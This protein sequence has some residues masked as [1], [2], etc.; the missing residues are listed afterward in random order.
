MT[1]LSVDAEA[2]WRGVPQVE[3]LVSLL[4]DVAR[5]LDGVA[6][7]AGVPPVLAARVTTTAM[8]G[9]RD[10]RARAR[11]LAGV[12]EDLRRRVAAARLADAPLLAGAGW[13]LRL[14]GL[15]FRAFS[16]Q[17]LSTSMSWGVAT[18]EIREGRAAGET[19]K[20][21]TW[22]AFRTSAVTAEEASA[23]RGVPA[24]LARTASAGGRA[25]TGAGWALTAY[26]NLRDPRLSAEQKVGRTAA[27]IATGTGVSVL[28]GAASGAAFGSA[29]GPLGT[30]VG[31]GAGSAWTP[32]GHPEPAV[33]C[34]AAADAAN[35][36]EHV[37]GDATHAV[38]HVGG[39]V[40]H[41]VSSVA[42]KALGV[43]GL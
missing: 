40:G 3:Q 4:E 26:S 24:A 31:F 12:P 6:V 20:A 28:A 13:G 10:L 5:G 17:T 22:R 32:V 36:V 25:V 43:V 14:L 15:H 2:M 35:E 23:T 8:A 7:P 21:G 19:Y 30:L 33:Q 38:G 11:G 1:V 42:H 16:M 34:D 27:S 29:A 37:G 41:G 18:R 9:A 39:T